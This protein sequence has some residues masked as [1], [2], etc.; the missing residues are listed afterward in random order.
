MT[1]TIWNLILKR[2][3]LSLAIILSVHAA[4]AVG[5]ALGSIERIKQTRTINLGYRDSAVP[6]SY[7]DQGGRP[8]GYSVELCA[9]IV[10]GLKREWK[11]PD[12]KINWVLVQSA[13]R[14]PFVREGK[15]DIECGNTTAT[16]ERRKQVDFTVPTFVA[17]SGVMVR[18]DLNASA[19][20][21]LREK[22]IAVV[23][24]STGE[25][26]LARANQA[27]MGL[28]EVPVKSNN[29]AFASMQAKKADA[30]ITDDIL[31]AAY[32]A[33]HSNPKEFKLLPRRH[34]IEPL[35][36][37][38]RKDEP[39]FT[40][41]I[42]RELISLIYSG[43]VQKTYRRWFTSPVPPKGIN[44][45]VPESRFLRETWRIPTKIQADVDVILF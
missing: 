11:L 16:A 40:Q 25:K 37:M 44:L 2:V 30:W 10:D 29:D 4:N 24:G 8:M 26:I 12:L 6:F 20:S 19:L 13:E 32:R 1:S 35:A 21:D 3:W 15:V 34:T 17:G 27:G 33:Q 41:K 9:K 7:V 36:L 38:Y 22:K 39:E 45:E 5:Q 23:T 18:A 43:E 28:I 42:D 14:L 31:L